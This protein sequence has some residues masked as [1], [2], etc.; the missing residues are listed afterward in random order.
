MRTMISAKEA[1]ELVREH[2]RLRDSVA[3]DVRESVGLVLARAVAADR[4]Y[5]PFDRAT[6]DGYAV[7]TSHAGKT[8]V[9]RGE[10]RPGLEPPAGPDEGACVEIMTGSPCPDG[11]EAVVMKEEV[12]RDAATA[13]LP[14]AIA[15]GQHIVRRGAECAAGAVV[16]AAGA[17]VTPLAIGLLETVG[18]R[19]VH[20]HPLPTLAVLVT[21]DELAS[22]GAAP[23]R[24]EIRDSNGPMLTAMARAVGVC[25]PLHLSVRDTAESLATALD[26]A[27]SFDVVALTG[28]VSAGNYDLVPAALAAHGATLVFHK[29]KQQ[30]GKPIVFAVKGDRLFFGLPGTPLGCH[31]GFHRYVV[32]AVRKMAGLPDRT[33]ATGAL[34]AAWSTRSERQQFVLARVEPSGDAWSV[35]ALATVGSSDLFGVGS[36]NAYID[37]PEG[38]RALEAGSSVAF[39]WLDGS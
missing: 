9:V 3:R 7:R 31:L 10:A 4:D 12:R 23:G 25:E 32:R 26:A 24:V 19:T 33:P 6:M 15:R 22:S 30:P 2:A 11:T 1:A 14:A 35:R 29:V 39:E 21:G 5:P 38:T 34:A 27:S 16:L 37:V 13:T 20:V 28:G 17:R 36:A 18:A 8:V